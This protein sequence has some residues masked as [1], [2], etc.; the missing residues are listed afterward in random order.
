MRSSYSEILEE[1]EDP[2]KNMKAGQEGRR[3]PRKETP[4]RVRNRHS[5]A[6]KDYQMLERVAPINSYMCLLCVKYYS[7]SN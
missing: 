4:A 7:A 2:S 5:S 3:E 6:K 1:K